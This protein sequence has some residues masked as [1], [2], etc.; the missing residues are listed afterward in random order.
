MVQTLEGGIVREISI[1]EGDLVEKDQTL[2][3]IDDT[4][5]ASKL[6][7]IKQRAGP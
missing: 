5:F 1:G 2:M 4:G 7:E 3:Q 6:G